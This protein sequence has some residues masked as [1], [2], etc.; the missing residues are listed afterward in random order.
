MGKIGLALYAILAVLLVAQPTEA[1]KRT[2]GA[3]ELKILKN[4]AYGWHDMFEGLIYGMLETP[5][6]GTANC[7]FCDFVG[8]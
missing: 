3:C 6:G 1:K 2:V 8:N 5:S 7:E 4:S